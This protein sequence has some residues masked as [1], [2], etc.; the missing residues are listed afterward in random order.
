MCI[1]DRSPAINA[2]AI[3]PYS[4]FTPK[5]FFTWNEIKKDFSAEDYPKTTE[6]FVI[7]A[8]SS[9]IAKVGQTGFPSEV[10]DGKSMAFLW[11]GGSVFYVLGKIRYTDIFHPN[12]MPYET[13]Y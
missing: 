1:R 6:G 3:A 11:G 5:R 4:T 10:I 12:Q 9:I 8:N 13:V 2:N 7:P